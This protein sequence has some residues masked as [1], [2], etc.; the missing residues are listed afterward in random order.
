MSQMW[1]SNFSLALGPLFN[2]AHCN[3]IKK[4]YW[5]DSQNSIWNKKNPMFM[6]ICEIL[7]FEILFVKWATSKSFVFA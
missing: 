3:L 7:K 1:I 5:G 2:A 4:L 6:Y